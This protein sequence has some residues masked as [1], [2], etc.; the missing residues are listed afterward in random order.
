MVANH[1][2]RDP[3]LLRQ[4]TGDALLDEFLVEADGVRREMRGVA[5]ELKTLRHTVVI[6]G[7]CTAMATVALAGAFNT[8][9]S[10]RLEQQRLDDLLARQVRQLAIKIEQSNREL[11]VILQQLQRNQLQKAPSSR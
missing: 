11:G 8:W 2:S 1:V 6:T 5:Q 10:H 3:E 9:L 7:V 4:P